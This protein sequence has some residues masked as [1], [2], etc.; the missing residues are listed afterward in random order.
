VIIT[1]YA[2]AIKT[3]KTLRRMYM[4]HNVLGAKHSLILVE[5]ALESRSLELL[6]LQHNSI[7][8]E[9]VV[10][11]A[12][13]MEEQGRAIV[14]RK[15][16]CHDD[17]HCVE[18]HENPCTVVS[19]GNP[20]SE[21]RLVVLLCGN[22]SLPDLVAWHARAIN[23]RDTTS[24]NLPT[25]VKRR[26]VDRSLPYPYILH[27]YFAK[28]KLPT[29]AYM[30]LQTHGVNSYCRIILNE[31]LT[32][33]SEAF[34][35]PDEALFKAVHYSDVYLSSVNVLRTKYQ[36]VGAVALMI[37]N[38]N[39]F[40]KLGMTDRT[41]QSPNNALLPRDIVYYSD[42][43]YT[44]E[45]V[46]ALE[47]SMLQHLDF[48]LEHHSPL[49]YLSQYCS[50]FTIDDLAASVALEICRSSTKE[51]M[52]LRLHPSLVAACCLY[53]ALKHV[54]IPWPAVLAEYT[55]YNEKFLSGCSEHFRFCKNKEIKCKSVL[56]S[57]NSS[58][59]GK[60]FTVN[61]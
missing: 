28:K 29:P 39:F 42:D 35:L 21:R 44:Q 13:I 2:N 9:G 5:A 17:D 50:A 1:E 16:T 60:S 56:Q 8:I 38:N 46:M 10:N 53:L 14:E 41:V 55:G 11:I 33:L 32:D 58:S 52:M 20:P 26:K 54:Q 24:G 27:D 7:E 45:E 22:V 61:L 59:S 34:L 47:A 25:C 23:D 36:L 3:S 19:T 30:Q 37:A 4:A 48:D 49:C 57:R 40:S 6:D 15:C 43:S 12:N 18:A 31:W 51:Y